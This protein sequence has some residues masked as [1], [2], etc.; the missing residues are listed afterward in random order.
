MRAVFCPLVVFVFATALSGEDGGA[1]LAPSY[2]AAS[3][4]NSATNLPALAPNTIVTVYGERLAF[5]TRALT[6]TDIQNHTLPT[7]LPGTGVQILISGMPAHLYYVSPGQINLL[8][9]SNLLGGR[10]K[11]QLLRNGRAGPAV[12]VNLR[13]AAPALYQYDNDTVIGLR[14]DGSLATPASPARPGEVMVFYA[15]GLGPVTP[16]LPPGRLP[17]EAAWID[18]IDNFDVLLDGRPI[19]RD[20]IYYAG[21]APGFAGLYQVNARIPDLAG[22]D[23]EIQLV[24]EGEASPPGLRLPCR[25]QTA[26]G[27]GGPGATRWPQA[28]FIPSRLQ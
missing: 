9:P 25:P 21:V 2:S 22:P 18:A 17:E 7:V 6:D 11:L 1:A 3:V 12:Y 26:S 4:V 5:E 24:L 23:P 14:P 20:H 15:T 28:A 13:Q 19:P 27:V 10:R 8:I 16:R